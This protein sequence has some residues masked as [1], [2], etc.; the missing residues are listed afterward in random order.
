MNSEYRQQ[1]YSLK[2]R[3]LVLFFM[4]TMMLFIMVFCF[5]YMT[6]KEEYEK[7]LHYSMEYFAILISNALDRQHRPIHAIQQTYVLDHLNMKVLIAPRKLIK[8]AYP[9]DLHPYAFHYFKDQQHGTTLAY[10]S[11]QQYLIQITA[12]Q[13]QVRHNV[14]RLTLQHILLPYV[15][16]VPIAIVLL[17]TLLLRSFYPLT[18]L[19]RRISKRPAD[20]LSPL[21]MEHLPQELLPLIRALNQMFERIKNDRE[22]QRQFVAN[23]AHELRTPLT[24]LNLQLQILKSHIP[25]SNE[26]RSSFNTVDSGLLRIQNLV[27][28]MMNLAHQETNNQQPAQLINVSHAL[29]HCIEQLYAAIEHKDIELTIER[30][31]T[32]SLFAHA[33]QINSIIYNLLDNA[34]KYTPQYGIINISLF[35]DL[36]VIT[37]M[38]EDSGR[39]IPPEE[40]DK[41]F[42]RFYRVSSD[43]SIIG[44]GLGLSITKIAIEQLGGTIQLQASDLGGV[45][46]I[47]R[48]PVKG[49][50]LPQ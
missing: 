18:V 40:L 1:H 23:A 2:K 19:E 24:A 31:E 37:L 34:I 20:E 50:L 13:A 36:N 30:L 29:K 32:I 6:T 48:I 43:S 42:Q 8:P 38:I 47:V 35:M 46:A 27:N 25:E 21:P 16:I 41:V 9:A 28:Q 3:T 12:S 5:A 49:A 17:F 26:A 44:S 4:L 33:E 7:K 39:G 45:L 22:K 10:Q 14:F 11:N 15:L